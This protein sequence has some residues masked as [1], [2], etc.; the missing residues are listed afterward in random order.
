MDGGQ[1]PVRPVWNPFAECLVLHPNVRTEIRACTACSGIRSNLASW[2]S[3][4]ARLSASLRPGRLPDC[5]LGNSWRAAAGLGLFRGRVR[6]PASA[7][8]NRIPDGR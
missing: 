6:I 5:H 3:T 1:S 8:R 7:C 4:A 2:I